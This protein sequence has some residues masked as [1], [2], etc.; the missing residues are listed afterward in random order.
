MNT[1]KEDAE[2]WRL[3]QAEELLELFEE[4]TGSPART[5]EELTAWTS[6]ARGKFV[7]ATKAKFLK[8]HDHTKN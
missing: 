1:D 6:S 5:M 7:I 3:M 2:K 4:D 8:K